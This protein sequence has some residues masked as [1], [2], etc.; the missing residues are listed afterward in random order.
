MED[1][2]GLKTRIYSVEALEKSYT[3][4][5]KEDI[6]V[7]ER[8]AEKSTTKAT[9]PLFTTIKTDERTWKTPP[10]HI[11]KAL[12]YIDRNRDGIVDGEGK[13]KELIA[14]KEQLRRAEIRIKRKD[15]YKK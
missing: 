14:G 2:S 4:L 11:N 9:A 15:E 13:K 10:D 1:I 3:D 7:N 6:I 5:R 12:D 8:F